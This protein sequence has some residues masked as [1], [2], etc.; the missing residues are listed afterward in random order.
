L[1]SGLVKQV[2]EVV[3]DSKAVQDGLGAILHGRSL[4]SH[5]V[6]EYHVR[7]KAEKDA[8]KVGH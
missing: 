1:S 4:F 3:Q 2:A 6:W 8:K 7:K 5:N